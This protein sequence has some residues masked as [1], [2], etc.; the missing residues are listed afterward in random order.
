MTISL[1]PAA[2]GSMSYFHRNDVPDPSL[3]QSAGQHEPAPQA[4][5]GDCRGQQRSHEHGPRQS[6]GS[7]LISGGASP[8]V[9]AAVMEFDTIRQYPWIT[10]S[11]Q[12]R[13]TIRATRQQMQNAE[14]ILSC[15]KSERISNDKLPTDAFSARVNGSLRS[16]ISELSKLSQMLEED[17]RAARLCGG[18]EMHASS[19]ECAGSLSCLRRGVEGLVRQARELDPEFVLDAAS[20]PI[21]FQA[22]GSSQRS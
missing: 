22:P 20:E 10:D 15:F 5:S 17:A 7:P 2:Y 21:F 14:F 16:L 4:L 11:P 8:A 9:V 3:S 18:P 12:T 6:G 13:S 1:N 19:S